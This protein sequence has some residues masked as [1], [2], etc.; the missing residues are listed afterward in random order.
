MLLVVL[1]LVQIDGGRVEE[2]LLVLLVAIWL[3]NRC[4]R[5]A[6]ARVK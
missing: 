6:R 2:V 3:T 4:V 1:P 5:A